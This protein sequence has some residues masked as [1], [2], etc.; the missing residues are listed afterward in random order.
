MSA[1][2][3]GPAQ[4]TVELGTGFADSDVAVLVDGTEVWHGSG[5]TTNY[6]VGIADVVRIPLAAGATPTVEV[7]VG[8]T[9]RSTTVP[10]PATEGEVRLRCDLDPSGAMTVGA[11]PEGPIF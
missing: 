2:P 10:A 6:S 3:Q 8:D 9:A 4:L 5:I 7:R 11:A 1:Q